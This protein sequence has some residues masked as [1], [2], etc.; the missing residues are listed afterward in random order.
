MAVD[1]C[2]GLGG[3]IPRSMGVHLFSFSFLSVPAAGSEKAR[4]HR[5]HVLGLI[6]GFSLCPSLP[7]STICCLPF[8]PEHH[9]LVLGFA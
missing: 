5:S 8:F 6:D 7:S 3:R 4:K 9:T 1:K 2:G